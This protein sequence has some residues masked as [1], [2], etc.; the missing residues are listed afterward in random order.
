MCPTSTAAAIRQRFSTGQQASCN[1]GFRDAASSDLTLAGGTSFATP[2]F[3]GMVALLNQQKGYTTGQGLLNPTLYTLASNST[4]Y[5]AVFHDITTGNNACPAS[6]G[7]SYCSG[8]ATTKYAAAAGYDEATGLGSFDV[9]LLTTAWPAATTTLAATT[10][11]V[12]AANGSPNVSTDDTITITVAQAS[13][14]GIPTGTVNLSIDGSGSRTA[15]YQGPHA[16]DAGN[17]DGK[18]HRN[19]H[20]Q[21]CD[22]GSA[23][24]RG[25]VCGRYGECAFDRQR[26]HYDRRNKLR[27]RN[28]RHGVYPRHADGEARFARN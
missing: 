18:R 22:H 27:Q 10:T 13:G 16:L 28:L 14:S 21:L 5:A 6:L 1:S 19:L 17:A 12:T 23:H 25:A 24:D 15:R 7:A 9:D 11:T 4:T 3:A 20:G 8:N 2:I 26:S